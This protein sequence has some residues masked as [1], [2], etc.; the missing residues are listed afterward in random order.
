[1]QF[2]F[3]TSPARV[4]FGRGGLRA[5]LPA[6]VERLGAQ[7]LIVVADPAH[8]MLAREATA[9]FA[10]ATIAW[11]TGVEQHVPVTV[12]ER[13]V[14]LARQRRADAVLSIGGGSTTGTA[15]IIARETGLP[16]LAV[17]TTY[18]GT[19]MTPVW[20][21]TRGGRRETGTDPAVLPRTVVLDPDLTDRMPRRLAV[22][23]ALHAM[24]HVIEAHWAPGANPVSSA[25]AD[26]AIRALATGLRS[27]TRESLREAGSPEAAL[28]DPVAAWVGTPIAAGEQLLYGAF[29]A[30]GTYAITGTG[31]HHTICHVLG[32]TFRLPDAA[33]HAVVLPNVLALNVPAVPVAADR[34]AHALGAD[35]AVAGIRALLAEVGAPRTL[36]QLGLRADQLEEAIDRVNA[37]LPIANPRPVGHAEVRAVLTAS[38]GEA[39]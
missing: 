13:A 21:L 24:A 25:L 34:I 1:M 5:A 2:T 18:A 20:G 38:F 37:V 32:G 9:P 31:L 11:F 3:E 30:G 12:A 7:R 23:S 6:E 35:D 17:P 33:T 10:E 4:L 29:L 27:L 15:K 39:A 26:E 19:E 14:A 22:A 36:V 8:E 28:R 16:I